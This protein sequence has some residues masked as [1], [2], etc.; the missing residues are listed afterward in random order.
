MISAVLAARISNESDRDF[1]EKLYEKYEQQMYNIALCILHNSADAEDA[2]HEAFIRIIDNFNMIREKDGH[3]LGTYFVII[4]RNIATD[5]LRKKQNHTTVEIEEVYDLS[6][7]YDVEEEFLCKC[8][9]EAITDA[10]REL[11]GTNYDIMYLHLFKQYTPREIAAL[12]GMTPNT[13][14]AR[15]HRSKKKIIAKLKEKGITYENI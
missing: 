9:V 15:I 14:S 3:V 1:L 6:D 5:I 4:V 10:V 2:V 13:V 7:E 12:L 8:S 11:S